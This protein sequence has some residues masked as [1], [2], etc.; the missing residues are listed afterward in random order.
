MKK[1]IDKEKKMKNQLMSIFA[2]MLLA[3][4]MPGL[5]SAGEMNAAKICKSG[6]T[7][8]IATALEDAL[9]AAHGIEADL[10]I[11][12]GACVSTLATHASKNGVNT[13]ALA[14][15]FCHQVAAPSEVR[16]CVDHVEP[17]FFNIFHGTTF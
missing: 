13:N 4:S 3:V 12:Q 17:A 5:V 9:Y 7:E 2:V 8:M 15:D 16:A 14:T 11:S 10:H 6:G 1:K